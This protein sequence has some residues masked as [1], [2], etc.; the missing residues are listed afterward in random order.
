MVPQKKKQSKNY[1]NEECIFPTHVP[2]PLVMPILNLA[3]AMDVIYKDKDGYTNS[4]V[5]LKDFVA[6]LL[7]KPEP[8]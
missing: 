7:I 5:V 8:L 4:G 1:G 2:L 6:S 3:H